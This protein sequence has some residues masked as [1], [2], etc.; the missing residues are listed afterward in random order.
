MKNQNTG[1][2]NTMRIAGSLSLIAL[3]LLLAAVFV[4]HFTSLSDFLSFKFSKP[5]YSAERLLQ[6]LTGPDGG[7]RFY[8]LPHL[9][10]YLALP[11]FISTSL[12]LAQATFRQTPWHAVI[13]AALTCFGVIFLGGV[14][15]AWLS[16]AAIANVPAGEAG[17]LLAAL[18]AL[19]TMR[20]SLM[21][22]SALSALTF[23][24]M[25]VL[26]F[27]LYQSRIIPRCFAALFI[28]GN[29]LIL[30]F[31]DLDN[32][33]FIGALFML[34]GMLPLSMRLIRMNQTRQTQ[35]MGIV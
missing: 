1:T 11:L 10:G 21:L 16:F 24:G 13:G 28:L 4:L 22:S 23:L 17:N 27:G 3:P 25:I 34:I 6:T 15:G 26:G 29:V 8:T 35:E 7:F 20:G 30:V 18:K 31:M 14:F 5:P 32:W 33:M 12:T 2:I 9:I 19:T